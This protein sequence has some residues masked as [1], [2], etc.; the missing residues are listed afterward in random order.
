MHMWSGG[1]VSVGYDTECLLSLEHHLYQ[2][3][4][5][6]M[7]QSSLGIVCLEGGVADR[8]AGLPTNL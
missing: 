2:T 5:Q 4:N 8:E 7:G 6:T 3:W 1:W